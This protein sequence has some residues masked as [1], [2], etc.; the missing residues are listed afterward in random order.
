MAEKDITIEQVER[1][2]LEEVH[3][4][5]HWAYVVG[6]LGISFLLMLVLIAWLGGTS[7]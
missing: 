6:V 1:E 7:S 5:A 4:G 2:H 3:R